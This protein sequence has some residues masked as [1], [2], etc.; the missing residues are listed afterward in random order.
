MA[1]WA[2]SL[3]FGQI[4]H[5]SRMLS[6]L[7]INIIIISAIIIIITFIVATT[8]II[9]IIAPT[10]IIITRPKSAYSR[11][12]LAGSW[13]QDTIQA[14]IFWGALNVSL[15]ASSAQLKY[16]LTWNHKDR[17]GTMNNHKK[18]HLEL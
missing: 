18:K 5:V 2:F 11:Q 10:I 8:I 4:G 3:L 14:R 12:G 13:G 15:R 7:F 1:W 17:P 9:T 16:K 6:K